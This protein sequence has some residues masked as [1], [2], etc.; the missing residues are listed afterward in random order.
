MCFLIQKINGK[1]RGYYSE[2]RD[3]ILANIKGLVVDQE[4]IL[5]KLSRVKNNKKKKGMTMEELQKTLITEICKQLEYKNKNIPL[6]DVLNR[7][8]E[9]VNYWLN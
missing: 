3:D 2:S 9:T 6:L 1:H 8:L 5:W 7:L 4:G